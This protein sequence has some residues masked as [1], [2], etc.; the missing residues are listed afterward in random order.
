MSDGLTVAHAKRNFEFGFLVGA[1]LDRAP[2]GWI[3]LLSQ[4]G[5][6]IDLFLLDARN[7]APRVFKTLDA[8][9]STVESIGFRVKRLEVRG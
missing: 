4:K 1:R 2:D 6:S 9:I 5:Y 3:C 7:H 8:A